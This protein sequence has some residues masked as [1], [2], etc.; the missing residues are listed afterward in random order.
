[1]EGEGKCGRTT[2]WEFTWGR[3][4]YAARRSETMGKWRRPPTNVTTSCGGPVARHALTTGPD[5]AATATGLGQRRSARRKRPTVVG[6]RWSPAR[7]VPVVRGPGDQ[8][9]ER[10]VAQSQ[11]VE[12]RGL[13]PPVPAA[14]NRDLAVHLGLRDLSRWTSTAHIGLGLLLWR[15]PGTQFVFPSRH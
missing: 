2:P 15:M 1:M 5:T 3:N 12:D 10:V 14:R 6:A 4:G 11:D 8:D 13:R 7:L 9:G